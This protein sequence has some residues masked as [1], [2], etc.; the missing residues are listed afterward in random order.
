MPNQAS[1]NPN[2]NTETLVRE[3]DKLVEITGELPTQPD[4]IT[5]MR[6]DA[7]ELSCVLK[8]MQIIAG[9]RHPADD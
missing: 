4:Y 7:H 8:Q 3:L 6:D 2:I 9:T 1:K 5:K